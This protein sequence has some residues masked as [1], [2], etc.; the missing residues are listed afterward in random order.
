MGFY[1]VKVR[2]CLDGTNF[3]DRCGILAVF[4]AVFLLGCVF[5]S[6]IHGYT[7]T[8]KKVRSYFLFAAVLLRTSLPGLLVRTSFRL[9]FLDP[10][11]QVG[12]LK[13]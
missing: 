6:P 11:D 4:K 8:R 5:V 9:A 10:K 7:D 13:M 2:T 1:L 3:S 12:N